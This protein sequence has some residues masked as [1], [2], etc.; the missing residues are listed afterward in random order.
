MATGADNDAEGA[1]GGIALPTGFSLS[2]ARRGGVSD[3]GL[4]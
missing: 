4:A 2:A 3:L 1:A